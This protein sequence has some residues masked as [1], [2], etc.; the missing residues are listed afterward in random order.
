MSRRK[1][2]SM[3]YIT[4][5]STPVTLSSPT[6]WR[7]HASMGYESTPVTLIGSSPTDYKSDCRVGEAVKQSKQLLKNTHFLVTTFT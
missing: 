5:E 1:R 3:G 4:Y 6:D 2:A 7:E